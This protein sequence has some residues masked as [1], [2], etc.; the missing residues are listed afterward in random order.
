[1]SGKSSGLSPLGEYW[2][3]QLFLVCTIATLGVVEQY[4]LGHHYPDSIMPYIGSLFDL[5]G[6]LA[7]ASVAVHLGWQY[8]L[9]W[10]Y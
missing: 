3:V 5:A 6:F 1:M 10:K 9:S 4:R 2:L 8:R 7:F